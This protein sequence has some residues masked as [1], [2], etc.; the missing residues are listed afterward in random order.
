MVFQRLLFN[1]KPVEPNTSLKIADRPVPDPFPV[2]KLRRFVSPD[3]NPDDVD[4]AGEASPCSAAG[5]EVTSCDSVVG[6]LVPV[7]W[8][9]VV[10]AGAWANGVNVD[11]AAEDPA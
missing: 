9:T 1:P 3:P 2:R 11:A 6:V 8:P 10:V 5:T 7:A 4:V